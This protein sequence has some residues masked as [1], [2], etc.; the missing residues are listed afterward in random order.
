MKRTTGVVV[1]VH[2]NLAS[3]N[4]I[5]CLYNSH[6][7]NYYNIPAVTIDTTDIFKNIVHY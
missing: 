2:Q 1:S 5:L 4:L 3:K 7:V 6:F